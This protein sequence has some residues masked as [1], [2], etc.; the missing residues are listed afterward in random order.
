MYHLAF[1][2]LV[3]TGSRLIM[4]L[5]DFVVLC[6]LYIQKKIN[7]WKTFF[8]V[9]NDVTMIVPFLFGKEI[10]NDS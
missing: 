10:E 4:C 6:L 9:L 7:P 8:V 5:G 3:A 1:G 2:V